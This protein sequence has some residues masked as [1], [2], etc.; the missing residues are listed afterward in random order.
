M[1]FFGMEFFLVG[2][3]C[4]SSVAW[5]ENRKIRLGITPIR[6]RSKAGHNDHGLGNKKKRPEIP[7]PH[8]PPTGWPVDQAV[9]GLR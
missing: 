2:W 7:L 8:G 1:L 3:K 5:V 4:F 9:L 6:G